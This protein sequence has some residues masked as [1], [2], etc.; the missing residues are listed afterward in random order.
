MMSDK[1][2]AKAAEDMQRQENTALAMAESEAASKGTNLRRVGPLDAPGEDA[3]G[4]LIKPPDVTELLGKLTAARKAGQKIEIALS[5][6]KSELPIA[7]ILVTGD[8]PWNPVAAGLKLVQ[9]VAITGPLGQGLELVGYGLFID[10]MQVAWAGRGEPF[11]V[12]GG[13]TFDL[14]DDIVFP[15]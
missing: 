1:D 11:M 6:G 12:F 10:D 14:S 8:Q 15:G 2:K 5:D 13:G 9:K 4:D 7:P 3:A